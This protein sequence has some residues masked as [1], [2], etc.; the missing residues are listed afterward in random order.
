MRDYK[1]YDVW[2]QSHQLVLAVYKDILP[3]MPK[4]E[5]YEL[6]S[7]MKR[8]AYSIPLS[9]AEG[10]GRNTDNDFLRFLDIALGSANEF[11]YCMLLSKDLQFLSSEKYEAVNEKINEIRAKLI[12]LIKSIR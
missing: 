2:Q 7:Q 1:K 5:Q 4:S 6:N 12:N 3:L 10:A 11:E 9:I 8:E